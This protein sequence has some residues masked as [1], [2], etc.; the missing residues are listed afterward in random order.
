[1]FANRVDSQTLQQ[2]Q[3][4]QKM[5]WNCKESLGDSAYLVD[6]QVI[7]PQPT[8]NNDEVMSS[9]ELRANKDR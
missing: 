7:M 5:I 1:M 9:A 2:T 3:L 8:N 4:T 6:Y